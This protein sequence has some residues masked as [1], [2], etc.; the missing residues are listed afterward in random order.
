ME[1]HDNP[2]IVEVPGQ[3]PY[4]LT[5]VAAAE[6]YL[7]GVDVRNGEYPSAYCLD[8]TPLTL[9]SDGH[10]QVIIMGSDLPRDPNAVRN[11][12][13]EGLR[14]SGISFDPDAT[15]AELVALLPKTR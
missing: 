9:S 10:D 14:R 8:G 12:L 5:S 13:M 4:I 3:A 2:V 15:V 7:E 6:G 11:L 1:S